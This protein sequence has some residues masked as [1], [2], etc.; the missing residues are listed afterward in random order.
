MRQALRLI[1]PIVGAALFTTVGGHWVATLDATTFTLSTITLLLLSHRET[2]TER[3]PV[4]FLAEL[5]AGLRHLWA[6]RPLRALAWSTLVYSLAIGMIEP[7][8]YALADGLHQ[9]AT[10]IAVLVSVQG[11]GAILG[12]I[13]VSAA[14]SRIP[15]SRL[16][17][18][19]L[20][21]MALG[22]GLCSLPATPAALTGFILIGVGQPTVSV[23]AAT[24]LQR[25]THNGVMGR[26]AAG[27][28]TIGTV[29]TTASIAAGAV[30][31]AIWPYQLILA[32]S[33]A[34]CA[35]AALLHVVMSRASHPTLSTAD[36][37]STS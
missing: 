37:A 16:V 5:S 15:E 11:G 24:L 3:P 21:L 28:D 1:G 7:T 31:V 23:A 18:A 19:G 12:G 10:F 2:A 17:I 22:V 9:P 13:G 36:V 33:A 25:Q 30:L 29:P 8:I 6:T 20:S 4:P 26:V 14:I 34:G 27:Y 35:T 32:V